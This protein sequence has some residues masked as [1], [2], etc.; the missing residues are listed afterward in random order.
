[1]VSPSPRPLA[2]Q[3]NVST[4]SINALAGMYNDERVLQMSAPVQPG[5][6]G[7]PLF[8]ASGNVVGVVVTK[9]NAKVVAEAMGDIPQNVNFALKGA[10]ARSFLEANGVRFEQGAPGP[11][12]SHAD[13][14]EIGRR[15]TVLVEC[16]K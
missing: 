15:V 12:R 4:G 9:L 6:S 1:V 2:D 11:S 5:S 16:W 8:D 14:G 7:G 10:V 3:V 13:I